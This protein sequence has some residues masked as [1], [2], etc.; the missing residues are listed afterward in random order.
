MKGI[1]LFVKNR[2]QKRAK[3]RAI[4][5]VS[6]EPRQIAG[7]AV[8]SDKSPNRLQ[9]IGCK[10]YN[11]E[12]YC[13]DGDGG[14]VDVA[15]PGAYA[16][17]IHNENDTFTVEGVNA[18]LRRYTPLFAWRGR[19]FVGRFDTLHVVAALFAGDYNRSGMAKY[20]RKIGE[21]PFCLSFMMPLN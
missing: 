21:I 17:S 14:C 7:F 13:T 6:R 10:V 8:A 20:R 9:Q 1:D 11:A 4:T 3:T 5:I 16:R 18:D 19:W 12:K 2:S 15:Y